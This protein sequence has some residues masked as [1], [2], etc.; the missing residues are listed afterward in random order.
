MIIL[1][2]KYL[3]AVACHTRSSLGIKVLS[4]Y[5]L[6]TLF[7]LKIIFINKSSELWASLLREVT[8]QSETKKFRKCAAINGT[9]N[10]NLFYICCKSNN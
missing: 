4:E 7:Y 3:Y 6:T 8:E 10:C 2:N 5:T 1:F 9:E